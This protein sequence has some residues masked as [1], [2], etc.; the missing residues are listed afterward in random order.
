M[1]FAHKMQPI[2]GLGS[3]VPNLILLLSSNH[4]LELRSRRIRK[5]VDMVPTARL[6]GQRA[7]DKVVESG[8]EGAKGCHKISRIIYTDGHLSVLG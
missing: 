3:K 7:E 5:L 2:G 1:T 4:L 8:F 6:L